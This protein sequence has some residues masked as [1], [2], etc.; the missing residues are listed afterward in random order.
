MSV[1]R[2]PDPNDA[3]KV[4]PIALVTGASRGIGKASAIALASNGFRVALAARSIAELQKLEADLN[5][6]IANTAL[7]IEMDVSDFECVARA[8]EYVWSEFGPIECL[9]NNAGYFEGH[10]FDSFPMDA[11]K[12]TFDV[13]VH[14]VFYCSRLLFERWKKE[15][16]P[17]SIVNIASLGALRGIEKFPMTVAYIAS[18]SAVVGL[19]EVLATEGRPFGI[20]VNCLAPGAVDT[21]M[22]RRAAPHLRTTTTP[23]DIAKT[24]LHFADRTASGHLSGCTVEVF[25]NLIPEFGCV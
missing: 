7:A 18:K 8:I 12:R 24:V 15:K 11:W 21:E 23:D 3:P 1:Y 6:E 14:G 13:N 17:G 25:S 9:V 20:R 5:R 19:S 4:R 10:P 2:K 16:I 22:L